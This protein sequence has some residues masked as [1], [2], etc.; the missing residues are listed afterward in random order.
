MMNFITRGR[1]AFLLACLLAFF[2]LSAMAEVVITVTDS[3]GEIISQTEGVADE[4]T[5]SSQPTDNG[6]AAAP[7]GDQSARDAFIDDIINLAQREF[8]QTGGRAQ[9]AQYSGDI[10][11]CKNFTVYLFRQNAGKYRMAEYPDVE[12]V[13]PDNRPKKECTVPVY[14]VEWKDVPAEEG[15]PFYVAAQFVYNEDLSKEE[16]WELARE[17]LK[18]VKRG[19]YFQMAANYYYGVGAHSMIYIAD[20]DPETDT[21]RWCDSNMKGEKRNGDRYG[22]VQFDAVKE[23]DWFVDAFCRKKHGATLYRLRDD[24]IYAQ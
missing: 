12:L 22:Y 24:I 2:C 19:D 8:E 10:Y 6:S 5:G 4:Q 18:Q 17:F 15:N 7:T 14:G 16:N 21:V 13:I 20:Y 3:D 11:V 23:I 9:R 1:L